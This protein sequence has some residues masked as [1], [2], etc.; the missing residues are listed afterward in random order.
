MARPAQ[1]AGQF[2]CRFSPRSSGYNELCGP[3]NRLPALLTRLGVLWAGYFSGNA[4][5]DFELR[6]PLRVPDAVARA[7]RSRDLSGSEEQQARDST[8]LEHARATAAGD[9][10]AA[11][12]LSV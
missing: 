7:R 9:S 4:E 5:A 8:G 6:P 11:R 3:D 2:L 1:L 12:S 10:V